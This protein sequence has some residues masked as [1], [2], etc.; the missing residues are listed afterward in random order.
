MISEVGGM[1]NVATISAKARPAAAETQPGQR[2]RGRRRRHQHEQ[3]VQG[4]REHAVEEP[5]QHRVLPDVQDLLISVPGHR[6]G[7]PRRW[8]LLRSPV[9]LE[10]RDQHP[11]QG[12]HEDEG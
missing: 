4:G 8:D 9:C 10:R 1:N 5:A 11:D 7:Q 6:V 12:R 2:V 3:R